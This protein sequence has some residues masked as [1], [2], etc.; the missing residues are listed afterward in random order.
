[1]EVLLISTPYVI[2][3]SKLLKKWDWRVTLVDLSEEKDQ[4]K[5]KI[6]KTYTGSTKTIKEFF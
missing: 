1:M 3:S 5:L 4:V 6:N 2:G